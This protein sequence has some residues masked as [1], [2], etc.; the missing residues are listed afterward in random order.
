MRI[1]HLSLVC[2][3]LL[4]T[5]ALSDYPFNTAHSSSLAG[6]TVSNKGGTWSL[7][8]NPATLVELNKSS[9]SLGHSN[10]YNQKF[11]PLSTISLIVSKYKL[12]FGIKFSSLTVTNND[13]DLL[14]E[15]LIGFATGFY[16]LNDKNSTLSLGMSANYNIINFGP[17]AGTS[18][19][20]SDGFN[21]DVINSFGLDISLLAT[22]REKNRLGVVIK[23]INSPT[24]G[25]GMSN[26]NL[27]RTIQIGLT[28]IPNKIMEV[29]FAAEQ[30][31]GYNDPQYRTAVQYRL[32]NFLFLNAGI[33]INPNRLGM[34]FNIQKNKFN[35]CY[36]YLTHHVLP[37]THQFN[38]SIYY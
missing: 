15:N 29:S 3:S 4:F 11:L 25:N 1:Y 5:Q 17:S 2:F 9:I 32:N 13:V 19:D 36:G 37:G 7:Y 14:K 34:G 31:L 10:L 21:I 38:F 20:G 30:L 23:N 16:L 8:H 28:T 18:G 27:P 22:L 33:Q 6:A 12:N 26:Q 24:I 35:I